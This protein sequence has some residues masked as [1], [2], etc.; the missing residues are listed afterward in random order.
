MNPTPL[1]TGPSR[2]PTCSPPAVEDCVR[3]QPR[4]AGIQKQL[5]PERNQL[6]RRRVRIAPGR[7]AAPPAAAA[8]R[9]R[10]AR[11]AWRRCAVAAAAPPRRPPRR[12]ARR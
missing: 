5:R 7:A 1:R 9:R 11:L 4:R 2:G 8:G 6:K 3:A 10:A 12:R